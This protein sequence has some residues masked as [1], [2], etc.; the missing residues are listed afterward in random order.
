MSLDLKNS[1]VT[2]GGTG[3]GK[4]IAQELLAMGHRV[5]LTGRR[6][7]VLEKAAREIGADWVAFDAAEPEQI[8]AALP[9]LPERVD[10]LVHSA[11]GNPDLGAQPARTLAEIKE[12][13]TA[14]FT[15]NVLTTVLV[16]EALRDRLADNGRLIG[17]GSIAARRGASGY[18]AAKAAIETWT[19]QMAGELGERGITVNTIAPGLIEET[20]FFG[21]GLPTER[22]AVLIAETANKRAGH[23]EDV[24][25][26][27]GFL[28]SERAGH[29]TGQVF[30]LNGGASR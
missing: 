21:P 10:V 22:K 15:A 20:E 3:I 11:G 6:A 18:G 26:L 12:S 19:S 7:D 1:I 28:A 9:N 4:A 30:P 5:V 8:T 14:N 29:L 25:A 23:P 24:A 13:W 2:G 17:I 16:T 27:A